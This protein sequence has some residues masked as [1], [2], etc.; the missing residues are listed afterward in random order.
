MPPNASKQELALEKK[1]ER[2]HTTAM[3][4]RLALLAPDVDANKGLP[5]YRSKAFGGRSKEELLKDVVEAVRLAQGLRSDDL[6]LQESECTSSRECDLS[7]PT[8]RAR[9]CRGRADGR[10]VLAQ[11]RRGCPRT[12]LLEHR[13]SSRGGRGQSSWEQQRH[14]PAG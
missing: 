14:R 7:T 10:G 9:P 12:G 2:A 5:G 1:N 3:W 8:P 6:L 4:A 13:R 11:G